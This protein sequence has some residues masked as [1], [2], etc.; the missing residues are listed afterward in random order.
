[1]LKNQTLPC[2]LYNSIRPI[3]Y[4]IKHLSYLTYMYGRVSTKGRIYVRTR[5]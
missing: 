1:M 4:V 5:N 2:I 3:V